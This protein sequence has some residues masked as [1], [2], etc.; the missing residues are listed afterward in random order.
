MFIANYDYEDKESDL[1]SI[2]DEISKEIKLQFN[3]ELTNFEGS[4]HYAAL[5]TEALLIMYLS[6]K[7]LKKKMNFIKKLEKYL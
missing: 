1:K 5:M 6:L 2:I 7:S 4:S 3:K